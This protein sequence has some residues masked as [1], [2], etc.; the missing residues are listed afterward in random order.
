MKKPLK[1]LKA[2][3]KV[4]TAYSR[5]GRF[6]KIQDVG[7]LLSALR[8]DAV[9]IAEFKIIPRRVR[10]TDLVP[11]IRRCSAD[12]KRHHLSNNRQ[13][14][15]TVSL[16]AWQALTELFE[17]LRN[18]Q[19]QGRLGNNL[20]AVPTG[21]IVKDISPV[22]LAGMLAANRIDK[23]HANFQD[24]SL[25]DSL[26]KIAHHN[27]SIS[28]YRIDG[29]GAHYLLLGGEHNRKPWFAEVLVSRLCTHS[30]TAMASL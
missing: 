10:G 2:S 3:T 21:A 12:F 23:S 19:D 30:A 5:S 15:E 17:I 13:A 28:G 20:M 11:T 26:N 14:M 16:K 29:R 25:R 7:P 9:T 22:E 1:S 24:M 6:Q 27:T 4:P 18:E 8:M